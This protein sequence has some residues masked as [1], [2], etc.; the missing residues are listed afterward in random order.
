MS[1]GETPDREEARSMRERDSFVFYRSFYEAIEETESEEDRL[2]LYDI[3][4]RYA[5]DG[6]EPEDKRDRILFKLFKSQIDKSYD[7]YLK[8]CEANRENG[9]K[10]GRP[11]KETETQKT[12]DNPNNPMGFAETQKTQKTQKN[13]KNPVKP[14]KPDDDDYYDDEDDDVDEDGDEDDNENE[15]KETAPTHPPEDTPIKYYGAFNNVPLTDEEREYIFSHYPEEAEQGIDKFSKHIKADGKTYKSYY[16]RLLIWLDEDKANK[17]SKNSK[18]SY[19]GRKYSDE[20]LKNMERKKLEYGFD[21]ADYMTGY[22]GDDQK[23]EG[24]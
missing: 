8:R 24:T 5:L 19:K 14:K 17:R 23:E 21:I 6:V 12:Q 7:R 11:P 16:A 20:D 1:S 2:R 13:R 4:V 18:E 10:G 3:I 22:I 15:G 9:K